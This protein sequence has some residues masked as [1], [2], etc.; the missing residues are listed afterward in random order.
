MVKKGLV[1]L[2]VLL[3]TIACGMALAEGADA[4]QDEWTVMFYFCGSDLE[5]NFSYAT[6]NLDEI[7]SVYYPDDF[8][9]SG[10]L[11]R[12]TGMPTQSGGVNILIETGGSRRWHAQS[13]GMNIAASRLQRWRYNVYPRD[14]MDDEGE[15]DTFQLMQTL[16]L[17]SMA[18]PGTLSDFIRWGVETCPAKKYA[19]V[20][21]GHGDG[22]RTGMFIDELFGNDIMYLYELRQ[23]LSDGGAHLE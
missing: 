8:L 6:G 23:A 2:A 20:L 16:P 12:K 11:A 18:S 10:V 4:V 22:A 7:T 19:L 21:W 1:V 5:S 15:R 9:S 14:S 17:K 13:L 3:L